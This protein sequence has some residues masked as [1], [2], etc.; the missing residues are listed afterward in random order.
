[1]NK[2]SFY[3]YFSPKLRRPPITIINVLRYL[4][5]NDRTRRAKIANHFDKH[6]HEIKE[7]VNRLTKLKMVSNYCDICKITI[8]NYDSWK[9]H[10][11]TQKHKTTLKKLPKNSTVEK[12]KPVIGITKKGLEV[13]IE[14]P[15]EDNKYECKTDIELVQ[16]Q[17]GV[18][19]TKQFW[20]RIIEIFENS[21]DFKGLEKLCE[22]YEKET[23]GISKIYTTPYYF[24]QT[25]EEFR[26]DDKNVWMY[27]EKMQE[28]LFYQHT[29]L[30][31]IATNDE[32]NVKKKTI[33]KEMQKY[34]KFDL[35]NFEKYFRKLLSNGT[36]KKTDK[37][38]AK[39]FQ[40]THLGMILIFHILQTDSVAYTKDPKWKKFTEP[41][42]ANAI[43]EEE[44]WKKFKY[45]RSKYAYLLPKILTDSN[46]KKLKLSNQ[47]FLKIFDEMYF[48]EKNSFFGEHNFQNLRK[49][50]EIRDIDFNKKL[51]N[52]LES[53]SITN[54]PQEQFL[55]KMIHLLKSKSKKSIELH[56]YIL[57]NEE[58]YR[59]NIG[60]IKNVSDRIWTYYYS[61][62]ML[63]D[64]FQYLNKNNNLEKKLE[65]KFKE[66]VMKS[67]ENRITFDF[68]SLAGKYNT[69]FGISFNNEEIEE[70]YIAQLEQLADYV[71]HYFDNIM[72]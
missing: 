21:N 36:I 54:Y 4:S 30:E 28:E 59:K 69:D 66:E 17:W 27:R 13:A 33:I 32:I 26:E 55:E 68:Y 2:L 43:S 58:K 35:V 20:Q 34:V 67:M 16:K 40:I 60:L 23:L 9:E 41:L 11:T 47:G 53:L 22:K 3:R 7:A 39:K 29:I 38:N 31:I 51:S 25:I 45:L 42:K 14:D 64:K 10:K 62:D 18:I 63:Y 6:D 8:K 19:T 15:L 52:Y 71:T 24:K 61:A 72:M 46:F 65:K 37:V 44:F 50:Y 5:R 48:H 1:M 57:E 56:N 49:F 12:T 70:W